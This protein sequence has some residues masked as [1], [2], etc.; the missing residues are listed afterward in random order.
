[1]SK[2]KKKKGGEVPAISTASLPDIVFMLLFFFMVATV[3]KDSDLMIDNALPK[4]DQVTKLEKKE[5][6]MS[7]YIGKPHERYASKFGSGDRIQLND[8]LS[9]VKD[10]RDFVIKERE[11]RDELLVPTL[12]AALKI[13]K[14]VKMGIVGDVKQEL[15]KIEQYKVNYT[16]TK[17]SVVTKKE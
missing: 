15:R 4:A 6:V 8:R 17:G 10:I 12:T 2:F 13:D 11:A 16:T 7:I 5:R 14:N 9:E 1:M 3:M